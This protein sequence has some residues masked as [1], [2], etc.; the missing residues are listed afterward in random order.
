MT[1]LARKN[2]E[3]QQELEAAKRSLKERARTR[4]QLD[5]VLQDAAFAV[6]SML[7]VNINVDA[8][9]TAKLIEYCLYLLNCLLFLVFFYFRLL[10]CFL[11]LVVLILGFYHSYNH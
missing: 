1:V 3:L 2:Q 4:R 10:L 6:Q 8:C 9:R 7:T 11:F 5:K